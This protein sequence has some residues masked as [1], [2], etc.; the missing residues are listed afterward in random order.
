MRGLERASESLRA[1]PV[2]A[3]LS[4]ARLLYC[5]GFQQHET[6]IRIIRS[7]QDEAR[8][9]TVSQAVGAK[10]PRRSLICWD[11][12]GRSNQGSRLQSSPITTVQSTTPY[13]II[14][15]PS[16]VLLFCAPRINLQSPIPPPSRHLEVLYLVVAAAASFFLLPLPLPLSFLQSIRLD[17]IAPARRSILRTSVTCR[18]VRTP[19]LQ[20][21]VSRASR[22]SQSLCDS[23]D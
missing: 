2:T 18:T 16:L 23:C 11:P 5:A 22:T 3:R 7:P 21:S 17:D 9:R 19:L 15:S 14:S 20:P 13:C 6:G 4:A 8:Y 1:R 12:P 10:N